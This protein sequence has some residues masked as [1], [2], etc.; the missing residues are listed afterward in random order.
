MPARHPDEIETNDPASIARRF[1][2]PEADEIFLLCRP[3][4]PTDTVAAQAESACTGLLDLLA[5]CGASYE[6]VV[7]ETVFFRNIR[8]DLNVFLDARRRLSGD[9]ARRSS[10]PPSTTLVQQAPLSDGECL[11]ISAH[12]VIPR[13]PGAWSA[14]T[15]SAAPPC[16]CDAHPPLH[17]RCM[18]VAGQT[19]FLAGNVHGPGGNALDE[20]YGMFRAADALLQEAEMT[21][22]DVVRTWIYV[23]DI[24]RDY[25]DLNRARTAFFRQKGLTLR[26]A[27]TGI[28]GGPSCNG[29]RFS[30]SLLALKSSRP[31]QIDVMSAPTLNEAWMYGSDF[32]RG[33][34]VVEANKITLHVSGTASVDEAGHTIHAGSFEAQVDRMLTNIST[35]L[36]VQGAS[37]RN[38]VCA[39]TYLKHPSD[40]PMLRTMFH[41][42]GFEGFPN[43]LVQAPICRPDLLCETEATALLPLPD[44]GS[45]AR[46]R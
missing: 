41:D 7:G 4:Q 30:L 46:G 18:R 3:Q 42:R 6:H 39:V 33:V 35:L 43:V 23:R 20:A 24:D 31:L 19:H 38:V 26:P 37:F 27:S 32:S 13:H 1:T 45:I 10:P 36:G 12:A 28:G 16:G 29:H 22:R 9:P 44:A 34:K 8:D 17:G 11:E 2:G 40:A 5:S 25:D 21:F 15:V 14:W